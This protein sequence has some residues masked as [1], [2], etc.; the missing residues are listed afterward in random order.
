MKR[1][2]TRLV[3]MLLVMIM[4]CSLLPL[5]AFAWGKMTHTYT[6]N[7]ILGD[8]SGG[9]TIVTYPSVSEGTAKGYQ[10]NIPKEFLEA[11]QAY[12]DAFRA[13]ALGPDVYPDIL[14]G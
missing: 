2:I 1:T 5:E 10:Y 13:G 8:S 9:T 4:C 11:I 7:K 6:A 3:S 14:T 12:P